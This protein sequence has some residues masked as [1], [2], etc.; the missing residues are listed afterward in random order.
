MGEASIF[1]NNSVHKRTA[2]CI[3]K[4]SPMI[5]ST[6]F[7][8]GRICSWNW[9]SRQK[10][11]LKFSSINKN[12]GIFFYIL[13][14]WVSLDLFDKLLSLIPVMAW[15][16][17]GDKLLTDDDSITTAKPVIKFVNQTS[18]DLRP[19]AMNR[20]QIQFSNVTKKIWWHADDI[21]CRSFL[22]H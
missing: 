20:F 3:N 22:H 19:L 16:R 15:C 8:I 17:T 10:S 21:P 12:Y 5:W 4:L 11:N 18:I 2:R 1:T 6:V 13:L 14:K 9:L 7:R